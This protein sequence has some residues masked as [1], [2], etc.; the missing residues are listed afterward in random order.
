LSL[1]RQPGRLRAPV[2]AAVAL[3]ALLVGGGIGYAIG[4]SSAPDPSV[5]DAVAELRSQLR[6]AVSGLQLLPNEYRQALS[7]SGAEYVG[8]QGAMKRIRSS[9]EDAQAD[10]AALNR[11]QAQELARLV[12]ELDQVVAAK[13]PPSRVDQLT[14]QANAALAQASG[15]R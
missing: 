4:H 1:Y 5:A 8:V 12:R 3:V 10:L 2:L 13:G 14:R 9:V 11:E 7:G 15:G 6:P